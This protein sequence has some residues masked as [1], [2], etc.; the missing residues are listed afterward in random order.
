MKTL[1]FHVASVGEFN[2]VKPILKELIKEH[3][4]VL[5]YFSP[6]AKNY[7]SQQAQYYHTLERL[8][9]DPHRCF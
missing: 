8:P 5:T 3:T 7:L 4:I 2:T 1:W 6:R 9:L